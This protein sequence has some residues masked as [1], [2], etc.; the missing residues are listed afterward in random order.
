MT[1]LEMTEMVLLAKAKKKLQW[2]EISAAL[3]L[4]EVFTTSA[5]LGQNTFSKSEAEKLG[6][7]LSLPEDAVAALQV[8]PTKGQGQVV[9]SDPLLY[10]FYEICY[11][12]GPTMKELIHEKMGDGIMSAIDF[13]MD[14]EKVE[15]PKGD[16]VKVTLNGKFLAY[17]KW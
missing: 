6:A 4:S 9:P 12:Y 8:F 2:A 14:I 3:G 10:R 13:T 11:V 16:R 15:D 17:K 1:K 7:M 5:C